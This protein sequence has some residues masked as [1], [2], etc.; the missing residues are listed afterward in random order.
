MDEEKLLSRIR[1]LEIKNA[2]L[3]EQMKT[4][5]AKVNGVNKGIGAVLFTI[6][7]VVVTS[8]VSWIMGGGLAK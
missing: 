6:I 1:D 5:T 4:V 7:G 3:E 8:V 2:V